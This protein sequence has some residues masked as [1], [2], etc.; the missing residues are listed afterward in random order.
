MKA[1][2][3]RVLAESEIF[4][5]YEQ[6]FSEATGLPVSLETVSSWQPPHAGKKTQNA[7]CRAMAGRNRTCA[8]CLSNQDKLRKA[9]QADAAT[10]RCEMGL[11]DSAVPVRLGQELIGFLQTG[12]VL[13]EKPT[14]AEF[15]RVTRQLEQWGVTVTPELEADYFRTRVMSPA[16]YDSMVRLLT[17]FAEHLSLVAN[18]IATRSAHAEPPMVRRARNF[19][20]NR[21][22]ED[23]SLTQVA[24]AMNVSTFYFCK[25]F[26]KHTG[27]SFTS[28]LARVRT[29]KAKAL[30][31][32]P[33]LR[34]SE[35]AFAVGFQSLTHFNHTFRRLVGQSPSE[36]RR[37]CAAA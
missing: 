6:A 21:Q 37:Q 14:A 4:R 19:I 5:E 35:I 34:I 17:I 36:Y 22:D 9:A 25:M 2:L 24:Q 16:Q 31:L 13:C 32:D 11:C 28:Y 18:Q 27:L 8:A 30:L 29:E 1:D 23:L 12:Q 3:A 20:A 10:V 7:F 33:D 26:K 15:Q